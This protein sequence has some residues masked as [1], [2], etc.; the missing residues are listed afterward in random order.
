MG[1]FWTWMSLRRCYE[2]TAHHQLRLRPDRAD[3]RL[4]QDV[5]LRA[6]VNLYGCEI[7]DES[8]IGTFVEIQKNLPRLV[9]G[10]RSRATVH[11]RGSDDRG[12]GLC[13][14]A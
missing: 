2:P 9:R 7:G 4:A 5:V 11:L 12:R 8:R 6:F 10:A 3:V 1:L 13:G 14:A